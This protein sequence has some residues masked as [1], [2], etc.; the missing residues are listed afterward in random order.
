MQ[1]HFFHEHVQDTIIIFEEGNLPHPR[2]P[3]CDIFLPWRAL[4]GRN[5]A[6]SQFTKGAEGKRRWMVEEELREIT[7]RA[8]QAYGNC[9]RQPI[10]LS[11]WDRS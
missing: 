9:Y 8:F 7:E 5:L 1:V 4:N 11:N 10:R 6:T 3:W 2:C